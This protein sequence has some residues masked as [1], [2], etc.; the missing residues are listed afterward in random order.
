MNAEKKNIFVQTWSLIR[1]NLTVMSCTS[2]RFR[3]HRHPSLR[4]SQTPDQPGCW[5]CFLSHHIKHISI[6]LIWEKQWGLKRRLLIFRW[7]FSLK[8][9]MTMRFRTSW[10]LTFIK[11]KTM[12]I[13]IQDNSL[14]CLWYNNFS[15]KK[16]NWKSIIKG[17]EN[18][19]KQIRPWSQL[20][21]IRL[22]K[23]FIKL[24]V[25]VCAVDQNKKPL[26]KSDRVE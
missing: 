21:K 5:R 14:Y 12:G 6:D 25:C 19:N 18:K 17:K 24:S 9:M 23:W 4:S 10:R 2:Q 8:Q 16:K 3:S 22:Q 7:I 13:L 26:Y 1:E 15:N 20:Y 11:T